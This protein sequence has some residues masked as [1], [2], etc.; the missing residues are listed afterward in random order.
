MNTHTS[1]H[2]NELKPKNRIKRY[3]MRFPFVAAYLTAYVLFLLLKYLTPLFNEAPGISS[4]LSFYLPA[5]VLLTFVLRLYS[6]RT[7]GKRIITIV[8]ILSHA[9]LILYTLLMFQNSTV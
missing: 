5:G 2:H 3:L 4:T 9:A 1:T 6:E 7:Q 8:H